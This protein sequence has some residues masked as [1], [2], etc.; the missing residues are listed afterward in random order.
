MRL[1]VMP[2]DVLILGRV[3]LL[4]RPTKSR[5]VDMGGVPPPQGAREKKASQ[6]DVELPR[7]DENNISSDHLVLQ[8]FT[9]ASL[10]VA[11][12][13]IVSD[14]FVSVALQF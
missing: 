12:D 14:F 7:R 1:L 6:Y 10:R 3:R 4:P 9:S 5:G 11:C 8:P 2:E 13:A